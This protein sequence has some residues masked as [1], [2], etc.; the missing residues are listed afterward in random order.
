MTQRIQILLA[1]SLTAAAC[2]ASPAES[3]AGGAATTASLPLGAQLERSG[4]WTI[5]TA[6]DSPPGPKAKKGPQ[7]EL[8]FYAELA[9]VSNAEAQKRLNEQQAIRPEF[10][11]LI[12]TL[13]SK[14][15][16]N[17]TDAELVHRPDWS[18]RLYFKRSPEAT[19]AK[20]TK[21]PRFEARAALY[22]SDELNRM[23]R[24]WIERLSAERLVTGYGMNARRGTADVDMVV[25]RAEFDE[26]ARRNGW[27]EPPDILN[28]KFDEGPVGPAVDPNVAAGVRIYPHGDRNLGLTHMAAIS[29]RIVLRDGCLFV[30][31][32]DGK[33]QLAYFA[34]EVGLGVDPAGYLSLHR[35]TAER[36]HLGRIGEMFT[37]AGPI[38]IDESAPMARQLREQCGDA[39]LM[40]VGIPDSTAMFNARWG[41][42][43]PAVPPPPPPSGHARAKPRAGD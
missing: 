14:E 31:G 10:Q 1:A 38:A 7:N 2:S 16:G 9:G 4:Y 35:R 6:P 43:R 25:S 32:L 36:R 15:R 8:G 24:P 3:S 19:L 21:N 20:Y 23:A 26:I 13:R 37:W 18:Y 30:T 12:A 28:L 33:Q 41:L 17:F 5:E 11:R 22:T 42:P 39:P 40:H 27:G 29:G 34:R